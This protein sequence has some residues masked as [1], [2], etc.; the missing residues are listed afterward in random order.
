MRVLSGVKPSGTLHLGHYFSVIK[1]ALELENTFNNEIDI[2]IADLHVH[3]TNLSKKEIEIYTKKMYKFFNLDFQTRIQSQDQN[4]LKVYFDLMQLAGKGLMDR[5]HAFK[6][7]D[8]NVNMGLY[9]Y[10]ILMAAD[11]YTSNCTH[12]LVGKD[13]AQHVE[14]ARD[15][16]KKYD[17]DRELPEPLIVQTE[18]ILGCDGEKMSKS[19]SNYLSLDAV[20]G[21]I[22]EYIA[23]IKTD[24]KAVEDKKDMGDHLLSYYYGLVATEEETVYYIKRLNQGGFRYDDA[25]HELYLKLKAF[26]IKVNKG[27]VK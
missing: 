24:S 14:I 7:S 22:V 18:S 13:Q 4:L 5:C 12:V 10:P 9:T 2:L 27:P 8:G 1:P 3:N 17:S 25:K 20:D 6:A 23:K 11:I 26:L 16:I 21:D 19:S 15:L